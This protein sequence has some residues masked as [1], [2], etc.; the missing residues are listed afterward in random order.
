MPRKN[1]ETLDVPLR[2]PCEA[3]NLISGDSQVVQQFV[4]LG[5]I[6]ARRPSSERDAKESPTDD[7]NIER[8]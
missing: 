3:M 7:T 2:T 8:D 5:E 4:N 6:R 1:T